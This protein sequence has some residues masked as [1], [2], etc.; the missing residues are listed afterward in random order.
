MKISS[1]YAAF[2]SII[3][4]A[5]TV[6]SSAAGNGAT[7]STQPEATATVATQQD[8]KLS[9]V[10]DVQFNTFKGSGDTLVGFNQ[11]LSLELPLNINANL[12][13]PVYSQGD[14][15]SLG[16][17]NLGG[18]WKAIT[19]ENSTIGKWDLAVGGGVYLPVGAEFFRSQNVNPYLN[20]K[21]DCKAW[22]LDFTQTAEYR[23][24]GGYA[25]IPVLGAQTDSDLLTLGSDLSYKW[26]KFDL[27]VQFDQYYYVNAGETQLFLGPVAKWGVASNVDL[28]A[29]VLLPVYQ[30]VSTPEANALI[31]AGLSI[32]F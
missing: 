24:D 21:F 28:K 26:G 10:E 9:F 32:K 16:D 7:Q 13:L 23:F 2:A 25:Y 20:A 11:T 31:S 14:H 6:A 15:S 17:I 29:S 4:G 12:S 19:G 8:F 1:I 5:T 30:D 18:S 27:G 22:V 3:I